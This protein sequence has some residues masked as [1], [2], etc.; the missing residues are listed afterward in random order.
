VPPM[1][2]FSYFIPGNLSVQQFHLLQSYIDFTTL[3]SFFCTRVYLSH[4][5]TALPLPK[6]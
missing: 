2:L 5:C 4:E 1:R 3:S 6:K